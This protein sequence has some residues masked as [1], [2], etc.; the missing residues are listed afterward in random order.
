MMVPEDFVPG[1]PG[2]WIPL[3]D[4]DLSVDRGKVWFEAGLRMEDIPEITFG[5]SHEWRDG[6]K[7]STIW[8][9]SDLIPIGYGIVPTFYNIDETRDIFTPR[10]R[11]YPSGTPIL[12]SGCVTTT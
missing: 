1:V 5:Y 9:Q 7:D 4:D 3:Y 12:G 10:F 11:P 8:G 2:A 6:T